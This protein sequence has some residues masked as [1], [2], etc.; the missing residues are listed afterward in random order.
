MIDGSFLG[1][2]AVGLMGTVL[3]LVLVW[4]S[5]RPRRA[6]R[7]VEPARFE[8]RTRAALCVVER[9]LAMYERTVIDLRD[10]G[11][12]RRA[13]ATPAQAQEAGRRA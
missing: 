7:T 4:R 5:S 13:D 10:G 12:P 1:A 9:H 6:R 2:G 8:W 11:P 3:A